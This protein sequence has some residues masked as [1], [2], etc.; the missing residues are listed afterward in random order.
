MFDLG[1][2]ELFLIR[3]SY[4][5]ERAKKYDLT[6]DKTNQ[7]ILAGL[8]PIDVSISKDDFEEGKLFEAFER[9][10]A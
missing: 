5:P 1:L 7:A 2:N 8:D 4:K 9:C 3:R 10:C 6:R